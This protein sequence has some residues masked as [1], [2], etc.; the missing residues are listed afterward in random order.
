MAFGSFQG[1]E[2]N[3]M[4]DQVNLADN[5]WYHLHWLEQRNQP[6]AL[7]QWLDQHH[8]MHNFLAI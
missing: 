4:L 7:G 8:V 6:H 2:E 1:Y 3:S 5:R